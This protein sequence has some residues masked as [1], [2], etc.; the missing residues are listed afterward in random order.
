M[1]EVE[2]SSSP[3]GT[4]TYNA[5]NQ[6]TKKVAGGNTTHYV[7]G[8]GGL[9]YGEYDNAGALIREYVYLND[10]PLAQINAGTP[11]TLTYLHPDH[12]GTPKYGTNTGGSQVWAWAPDAFGNGAPSG[13]ATV[14]L[15]MPGQYYDA[16]SGVFYNWNRYYNPEIG[17]YI[18]SDPIGLEGGMNTF[19]YVAANPLLYGDEEG[20]AVT[21]DTDCVSGG[22][23]V[24]IPCTPILGG[25]LGGPR[26]GGKP[27]PKSESVAAPGVVGGAVA[28]GAFCSQ[29]DVDGNESIAE[30]G[31]ESRTITLPQQP[32]KGCTCTCRA[33]ANDNIVG[34]I[35]PGDKK[36]AFGTATA[37]SCSAASKE[38]KRIA[39]KALGK[40]PKHSDCRCQGK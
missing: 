12:L 4:Y 25:G 11:E 33:D 7:Y 17:R 30:S 22:G 24:L 36:F 37:S 27:T 16:E 26:G 13:A 39:A 15:R 3:V 9:L 2:I 21:I 18:S 10:A 31:E 32:N 28:V 40:Q 35:Q 19:L 20:L 34:N 29:D 6:R 8:A 5:S 14:N 23:D 38:A 1:A